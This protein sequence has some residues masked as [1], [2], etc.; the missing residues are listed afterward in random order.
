MRSVL[1]K[2]T[3]KSSP[4][5]INRC[6]HRSQGNRQPRRCEQK[7]NFI[8]LCAMHRLQAH[9]NKWTNLIPRS[10][11]FSHYYPKLFK[12]SQPL[13]SFLISYFSSF[14]LEWQWKRCGNFNRSIRIVVEESASAAHKQTGMSRQG[15]FVCTL[16]NFTQRASPQCAAVRDDCVARAATPNDR[17]REKSLQTKLSYLS[18]RPS[19]RRSKWAPN[20]ASSS[21]KVTF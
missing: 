15:G 8:K 7:A 21:R 5:L 3:I 16:W 4:S 14:L 17:H 13:Q 19:S 20:P 6:R 11:Y 2:I 10:S 18:S 9:N 12:S 1:N